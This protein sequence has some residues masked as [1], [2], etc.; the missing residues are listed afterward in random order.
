VSKDL[1]IEISGVGSKDDIRSI[2]FTIQNEIEEL[3]ETYEKRRIV[4]PLSNRIESIILTSILTPYITKKAV[5][6]VYIPRSNSK[7]LFP[8]NLDSFLKTIGASPTIISIEEVIKILTNLLP[9]KLRTGLHEEI[10][11][12]II[13]K[14]ADNKDAILVKPYT[15]THWLLGTFN[16]IS[17]KTSDYLP[18]I[19]IYYSK[20][21]KIAY[22]YR[23]SRYLSK[24]DLDPGIKKILS[25]YKIPSI[26][27]LD[28][29]LD[30]LVNIPFDTDYSEISKKY[31]VSETSIK[32]I[33]TLMR[34]N[35]FKK[36]TPTPIP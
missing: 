24:A 31:K 36:V 8:K 16:E 30:H 1:K 15:Y 6:L 2:I 20:L 27:T 32:K 35:G 18:F 17:L 3:M 13:R 21:H 33:L 23:L 19:R 14:Y 25:E 34:D 26:D 12:V 4:I 10:S 22:V 7:K 11:A 29:I 5:D 28:K 9:K